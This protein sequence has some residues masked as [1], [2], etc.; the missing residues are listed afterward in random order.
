LNCR[1]FSFAVSLLLSTAAFAQTLNLPPRPLKA[2]TGSEFINIITPMSLTERENWIYAQVISG[3]IPD[4]QRALVPINVSA[5]INGTPHTATYYVAPDYLA[6]GTDAD[7][8]L[9]P[10]SPLLAQRLCDALGCT[11]PTR[12]MVNQIW[13]NAPV[14][15]EPFPYSPATYD[16]LAISTFSL[17]NDSVRALRNAQTN[18]HPLGALVS[19]DKKDVIISTKIYTNFANGPTITNVVVIYGWHHTTG[20]PIQPLY[21]GHEETYADYSHGTRFVQMNMIVDGAPATVTNVLTNPALAGLLSDESTSEG[22]STSGEIPRPRYKSVTVVPTMI[23]HPRGQ[24]V[25]PGADVSFTSL[26][27]GTPALSYQW[28]SNGIPV[29]LATNSSFTLSNV[30]PAWAANY[31]VA[32]TSPFGSAT[33]RLAILT[34]NTNSLPA[35]FA[36]NFESGSFT[37]WNFFWAASNNI[38]D[39]TVDWAYDYHAIP[40]T[41]NGATAL[42]PPA[43]NSADSVTRALRFTVN[44]NDTTGSIAAVNVYPKSRVFSNDFALKFDVWI[45]YPGGAAGTG[46]GVS[47]STEHASFGLNHLGTQINW[48]AP[49]G[50]S[51]DGIWFA[52]D[53]EGGTS[54]DYRAYVGNPVGTPTELTGVPSGLIATDAASAFFQSLFPAAR[55][56]TAGAPGKQWVQVELRQ[57]NNNVLWLID[58]AVVAQRT[59]TS[60]YKGGTVMLG[61][62]DLFAS[63]ANPPQNAFVL[64][65][66]VRVEDLSQPMRILSAAKQ[67]NGSFRIE[68]SA[69]LGR[70]CYLEASTNLLDWQFVTSTLATNAPVVFVDGNGAGAKFYRVR[71]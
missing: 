37:N 49:S 61:F 47:G 35:L 51:S 59:N 45:N 58:G 31:S 70:A 55:A 26:A 46:T 67:P 20:A 24:T 33:S 66:N 12:K 34:I 19:G 2:P 36:D 40:Y 60:S 3:N 8:F 56:E 7:Y 54:R 21:N 28:L 5:T 16:I 44:N 63:I 39:Y 71:Q 52:V 62:M 64:F 48:A 11:L 30:Q 32:V 17:E 14:K 27:I 6:I 43:P 18:A 1:R 57:T 42:I 15:L 10:T 9:E 23:T 4:F 65:D 25:R 68:C 22:T 69:L 50:S 38:P 29:S 13:T 41:F 53:G